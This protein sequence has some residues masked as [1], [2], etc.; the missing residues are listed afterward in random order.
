MRS[1]I[2]GSDPLPSLDEVYTHIHRDDRHRGVINNSPF[3][4]KLA[5]VS[6]STR[7]GNSGHG[8]G[9]RSNFHF[10]DRDR[11]KCEHCGRFS[12]TKKQ[13]WD[14]HECLLDLLSRLLQ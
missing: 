9:G 13:C 4:E 12:H 11:L 14:L 7:G 2:F 3:I 8:R 5:L 10:D 1:L 6:I